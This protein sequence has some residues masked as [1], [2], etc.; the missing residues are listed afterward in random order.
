MERINNILLI[1]LLAFVFSCTAKKQISQVPVHTTTKIV[2]RMIP[3]AMPQDSSTLLA[4]FECDSNNKVILE[5]LHEAKTS[6][7]NSS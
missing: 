6:R 1:T 4:L 7:L 5:Q 2:E 3:I